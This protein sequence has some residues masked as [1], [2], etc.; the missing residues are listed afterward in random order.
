MKT[1]TL[2]LLFFALLSTPAMVGAQQADPAAAV[3]QSSIARRLALTHKQ[4]L[5][6]RTIRQDQKTQMDA[7]RA[8]ATLS[9][10]AR[11]EKHAKLTPLRKAR[12]VAS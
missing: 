8:D 10:Q 7:L 1:T 11:R 5:Q 3:P 2:S 9:P 4:R 6:F 12:S